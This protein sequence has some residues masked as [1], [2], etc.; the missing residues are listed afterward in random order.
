MAVGR[1]GKLTAL[2]DP[3]SGNL[4]GGRRLKVSVCVEHPLVDSVRRLLH[5][6][7]PAFDQANMLSQVV[8]EL[9]P[10]PA[11][12]RLMTGLFRF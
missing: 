2:Q 6:T 1:F 10:R 8:V 5:Y 12:V 9:G 11:R 3:E 4:E 7:I